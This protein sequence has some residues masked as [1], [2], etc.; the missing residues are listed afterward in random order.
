MKDNRFTELCGFLSYQQESAIVHPCALA[1]RPPSHLPPARPQPISEPLSELPAPSAPAP[2]APAL[3]HTAHSQGPSL[4]HSAVPFYV[5]LSTHRPFPSSSPA[6][7]IG[8]FSMSVLHC[9][10]ENKFFSAIS[11]DSI[12]M[13]QNTVF[14]YLSLTY[15]TLYSGL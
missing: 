3:S 6:L 7:P 4:T 12:C 5:T 14:I 9:Y 11:S 15:F 8:L 13:C 2:S 1:P 10:P